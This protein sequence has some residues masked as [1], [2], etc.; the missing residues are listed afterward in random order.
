MQWLVINLTHYNLISFRE[1]VASTR[2]PVR[3]LT[4]EEI[5]ISSQVTRAHDDFT[6]KKWKGICINLSMTIDYIDLYRNKDFPH[7]VSSLEWSHPLNHLYVNNS[8]YEELLAI[9]I[10]GNNDYREHT[11]ISCPNTW[12]FKQH[13][14]LSKFRDW[15]Q[16][17]GIF[18]L[19]FLF[20][21]F[22]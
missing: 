5:T 11:I 7:M 17:Y 12:H 4:R 3:F 10:F 20:S 1:T 6:E 16:R 18:F 19:I 22:G 21:F 8:I 14:M 9:F 13:F 2:H 15:S